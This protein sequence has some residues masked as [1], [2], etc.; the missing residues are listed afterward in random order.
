MPV[1]AEKPQP[2]RLPPLVI[3]GL[4][5]RLGDRFVLT[6]PD[7]LLVYESDALTLRKQLPSAVII[8]GD[9][10]QVASAVKLLASHNIP[11]TP[12]GAGTGLSGGAVSQ[13][14]AVV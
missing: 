3:R 8:P 13:A 2:V 12:R 4:K 1:V 7:E 5:S 10:Q 6:E 11:F 9:A 14:G